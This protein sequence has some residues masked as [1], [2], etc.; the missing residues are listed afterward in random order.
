MAEPAQP[1]ASESLARIETVSLNA[2]STWFGL[3]ALIG[4]VGVTLLAH[5]DADFFRPGRLTELPLLG[6]EVP[7]GAF[8]TVGP[9]L[10]AAVYAYLQ[11]YLV[12]LWAA[13]ARA[14]GRTEE[15]RPIGEEAFPWL[16]VRAAFWL[17]DRRRR[18]EPEDRA[19]APGA[20]AGVAASLSLALTW[21]AGPAL[22]VAFWARAWP[23]HDLFLSLAGAVAVGAAGYVGVFSFVAFWR[24]M[25]PEGA[26]PPAHEEP[27]TLADS[28]ALAGLALAVLAVVAPVGIGDLLD[29]VGGA[30]E[31]DYRAWR[32]ARGERVQA[33]LWDKTRAAWHAHLDGAVPVPPVRADL[34]E[35]RLMARPEGMPDYDDWLAEFRKGWKAEQGLAAEA[36]IPP[37]QRRVFWQAAREGWADQI[38][39]IRGPALRERDLRGADAYR[40]EAPRADLRGARLDR[41]DLRE[42]DLAGARLDCWP[43]T[44]N[45]A[46]DNTCATLRRTRLSGAKLQ[47]A[48]LRD[49]R[50]EG[51]DLTGAGLEGADLRDAR[52][53]GADLSRARLEGAVLADRSVARLEGA[54]LSVARLKGTDLSDARLEGAVLWGARLEGAD[55][56][57]ARLEGAELSRAGLEGADLS[58]A[59]L[60]GADLSRAGLEG[61]SLWE[62]RLEGADL[63][64]AGLEGADLWGAR[65]EG[66]DCA[67]AG[68]QGALARSAT[69]LCEGLRR[70]EQLAGAIGNEDTHLPAGL[71]VESCWPAGSPWL[72]AFIERV[73]REQWEGLPPDI[74]ALFECAEGVAPRRIYGPGPEDLRGWGKRG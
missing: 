30:R 59:R 41:A 45:P 68:F 40:L 64:R 3:L 14:P 48:D 8:F 31:I 61:A 15:G 6:I 55:L 2:R 71:Y 32:E 51:A 24:S 5:R 38:A 43:E 23:A 12:P 7:V 44:G 35:V 11:L 33:P 72:A 70:Q 42:A 63:S 58:R 16:L 49:A 17:R 29:R 4:F 13:I 28:R 27:R 60:E 22:L 65:L 36:E 74:R 26:G 21:V 57:R 73:G 25:G 37:A 19:L 62:A 1:T 54:V 56:S 46:V 18:P 9:F 69:L 52:L 53:E 20:M 39:R 47:G 67:G 66:A 34:R 50:L 10:V